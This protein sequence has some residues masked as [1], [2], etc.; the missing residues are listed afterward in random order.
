MQIDDRQ[1]LLLNQLSSIINVAAGTTI[2]GYRG[3][4]YEGP[5]IHSC[6]DPT[7]IDWPVFQVTGR[8]VRFTGFRL[9]GPNGDTRCALSWLSAT[10]WPP[11]PRIHKPNPTL[12]AEALP[13]ITRVQRIVAPVDRLC[14]N[15]TG[16]PD[17]GKQS[18]VHGICALRAAEV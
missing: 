1:S 8:A 13:L 16:R 12:S 10:G 11:D 18:R 3:K 2:H 9:N 4:T 15:R 5:E 6:L 17:F 14:R 7:S